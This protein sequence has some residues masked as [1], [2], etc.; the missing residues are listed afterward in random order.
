MTRNVAPYTDPARQH[1]DGRLADRRSN[2]GGQAEPG[3]H[4]AA[5]VTPRCRQCGHFWCACTIPEAL[6]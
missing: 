2:A 3:R 5:G 6:R 1:R 4:Q